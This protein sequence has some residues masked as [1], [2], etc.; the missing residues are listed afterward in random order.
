VGCEQA[1]TFLF[2]ISG[3]IG[4][5]LQM[6]TTQRTVLIIVAVTVSFSIVRSDAPSPS[7]A[8]DSKPPQDLEKLLNGLVGTWSITE[9][10]GTGNIAEGEEI[11]R[12][13]PGGGL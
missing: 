8:Q 1:R 3:A 10:D 5:S 4:I 11:W 6:G 12:Q 2:A 13:E 9:D 7:P